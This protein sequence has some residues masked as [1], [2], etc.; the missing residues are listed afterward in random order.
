MKRMNYNLLNRLLLRSAEIAEEAAVGSPI[1]NVYNAALKA[2]AEAYRSAFDI[3]ALAESHGRQQKLAAKVALAELRRPYKAAR[4]VVLAIHP[5]KVVPAALSAQTTDTDKLYAI[6]TLVSVIQEYAGEVWADDL[7]SGEFGA[8]GA[9]AVKTLTSLIDASNEQSAAVQDR[10]E[11]FEPAYTAFVAFRRVVRGALGSS[12]KAYRRLR[13]R[14]TKGA[15][16][17]EAEGEGARAEAAPK[18]PAHVDD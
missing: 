18:A 14:S 5:T 1:R 7:L 12:S 2:K 13:V 9:E 15:N 16:E 6:E 17:A 10:A 3:I 4:A 8:K 11:A